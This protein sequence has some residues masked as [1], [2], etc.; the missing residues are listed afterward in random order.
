M[1]LSNLE[2]IVQVINMTAWRQQAIIN[3]IS[4]VKLVENLLQTAIS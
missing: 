2:G 4:T 3:Q 1:M